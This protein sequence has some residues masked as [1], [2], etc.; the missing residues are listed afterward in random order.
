MR[1]NAQKSKVGNYYSTPIFAFRCKCH[2]CSHWFEIRTDPQNAA[3]VVYEGAR[4]QESSWDPEK[5]GGHAVHDTEAASKQDITTALVGGISATQAVAAGIDP[6]TAIE[7]EAAQKASATAAAR[8]VS[9]LYAASEVMA[10]PWEANRALRGK[11]RA[12]KK[13]A[14]ELQG[15]DEGVLERYGLD[16]SLRLEEGGD[17]KEE[18]AAAKR[19]HVGGLGKR[20]GPLGKRLRE[21]FRKS[22]VSDAFDEPMPRRRVR[23]REATPEPPTPPKPASTG[24]LGLGGY[25][26][27]SESE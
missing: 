4:K 21:D 7:T 16:E 2:L 11:F 6:L 10:D 17:V 24:L 14:L 15:R 9:E 19:N 25:G 3:Y 18:F 1:Y 8:R 12:E 20:D 13:K 5:E 22:A 27:G 23:L 26:S